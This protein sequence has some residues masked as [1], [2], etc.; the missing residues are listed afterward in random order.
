[1]K[2]ILMIYIFLL[3]FNASLRVESYRIE[4]VES[5]DLDQEAYAQKAANKM[6]FHAVLGDRVIGYISC[7]LISEHQVIVRQWAVD[8]EF[9]NVGIVKDLLFVVFTK[10]NKIQVLHINCPVDSP[11]C[12]TLFQDLG[13]TKVKSL[14]DNISVMFEF[15]GNSKCKLCE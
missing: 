1:M 8:P 3:V 14:S 11:E 7:D 15:R 5:S 4:P 10:I 13:F 6:F 12:I 9:F 2:K